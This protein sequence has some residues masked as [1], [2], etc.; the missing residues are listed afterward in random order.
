M[1]AV[2]IPSRGLIHSRTIEHI[3]NNLQG[4][5]YRLYMSHDLPIPDCFNK[6]AEEALRDEPSHIWFVE[7]DMGFPDKI[8]E[9]MMQFIPEHDAV[10]VDYPITDELMGGKYRP[11]GKLDY[12]GMGCMLVSADAL[13]A[14]LP[15]SSSYDYRVDGDEA[16]KIHPDAQVYGKQ[17]IHF[18][19]QLHNKGY[20]IAVC[21]ITGWQY[22]VE[23]YGN[24]G[25]NNGAHAIRRL[26]A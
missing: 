18:Y 14:T 25:T 4:R 3:N 13:S 23:Q 15:F 26:R 11:D 9:S 21:P 17:D 5:D 6:I 16:Y 7:E 12:A 20:S 19:K 22:R 2:C 1:I 8:L 24:Q 10:V